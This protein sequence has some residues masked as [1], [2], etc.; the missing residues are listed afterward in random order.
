MALAKLGRLDL[1]PR[2][3]GGV[4]LP[5]AVYQEIVVRGLRHTR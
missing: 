5:T 1:L 3:Y 4:C 2:L